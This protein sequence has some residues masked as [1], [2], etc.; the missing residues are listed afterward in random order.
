MNKNMVNNG[1][2][3]ERKKERKKKCKIEAKAM[4]HEL[5]VQNYP[6]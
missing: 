3:R 2:F 4:C 5:L 1:W 6:A